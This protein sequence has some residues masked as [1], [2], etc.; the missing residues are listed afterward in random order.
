M[1]VKELI[2]ELKKFEG[3][4]NVIMSK[5][6]EGNGYSP[7]VDNFEAVYRP[8]NTWS[9]ELLDEDEEYDPEDWLDYAKENRPYKVLVL[10]PVN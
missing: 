10:V 5:D 7:Y 8:Y 4:L 3:D 2:A 1:T 9:G 6:P